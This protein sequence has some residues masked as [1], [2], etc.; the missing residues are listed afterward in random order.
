MGVVKC[1]C[2]IVVNR[3]NPF[4]NKPQNAEILRKTGTF[5]PS[6]LTFQKF[7]QFGH[8]VV[9]IFLAEFVKSCNFLLVRFDVRNLDESAWAEYENLAFGFKFCKFVKRLVVTNVPRGDRFD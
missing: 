6:N 4:N 2:E 5:V 8:F 3:C 1:C 7:Q 9:R